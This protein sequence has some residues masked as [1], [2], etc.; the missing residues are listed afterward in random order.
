MPS[1]AALA[2]LLPLS[3]GTGDVPQGGVF[4]GRE[5]KLDVPIPRLNA[6]IKL[7]GKL[8]DEAWKR[9]AMLTG[10]SQFQPAD[11]RPSTDSTEVL[12]WYSATAIHFG[13]RAHE[14][15]GVINANLADRDRI[16]ADDYVQILLGTFND[17][18]QA[19]M[20]AVNPLGVQADGTMNEGTG[21]RGGGSFSAATGGRESADLSANFVFESRGR[22]VEGGYEVEIT[23]PFKSLRYQS[24][25]VQ[26]WG[27]H[28]MRTV[29]HLGH[30]DSWVPASRANASFLSQGGRLQGLRDLRRGLVMDVTPSVVARQVGDE[31]EDGA[32]GYLPEGPEYGATVR[33]GLTNNL[34]LNATVNPDFS[35]VE[36]DVGAI[37]F[38]PRSEVFFPERR[39]FFL[40]GI[41][42]FSTPNNLV[43]SRRIVQPDAALKL[44]GKAFGT[45]IAVMS[46]LDDKLTSIGD[47]ERPMFNIVRLTRDVGGQSRVGMVY[48]DKRDG[49]YSN[50]V[51]GV[52]ARLLFK[53]MWTV[54]LQAA[55]SWT[56]QGLGQGMQSAPLWRSSLDRNGRAFGMTYT[57]AGISDE[58]ITR[59]GFISR[60]GVVDA[61]FNH[62]YT[63]FG[64]KGARVESF[65]TAFVPQFKWKWDDFFEGDGVIERKF[66]FNNTLAL[67][68]G[69]RVTGSVLL[70]TFYYDED[71]YRGYLVEV[72][73]TNGAG[74]DTIPFTGT[75]ALDNL[76]W[77]VNIA[78]PQW[79]RFAG[80]FFYVWGQDENFFEW[81]SSD[82]DIATV[83]MDWRP[84]DRARIDFQYQLQKYDRKTDGS[85][86]GRRRI[87]R[88]KVEYQ[89]ARPL[90]FR[91]VGQ[92]DS[93]ERDALR[94]DSRTEGPL[95]R[96][97]AD[98]TI[99][100]LD[101]PRILNNLRTD[102]LLSY[103]PVPGTVFFAGYGSTMREAE[104]LKF[105]D[106]SRS[107]DGF[108]VKLSYLWR[109]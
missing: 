8:D 14:A 10:F 28:V 41:E 48:T 91:V 71:L 69:W 108:F 78:T 94:D 72:P 2:F 5:R 42:T 86:V 87:P 100:R 12:V 39:P 46:A 51:A 97:L 70:E 3:L 62:R 66:H 55:N 68:G 24:A 29:Q 38:D 73:A 76:D 85:T 96:T 50:Q 74:L 16:F 25:E 79:G 32:W 89:V 9:A 37:Q 45:N 67:R 56:N 61:N 6:E 47:D 106:L 17:G 54:N 103:Q 58:F 21:G 7:D 88:L 105:N 18:R 33:W 82:I 19:F 53:Q 65:S 64:R 75:P 83:T 20:F 23:V 109:L 77:V 81:S 44:T 101:S 4:N 104:S 43:Y 11:G 49:D 40:E 13:I 52:D 57:F 95:L 60:T 30:E 34:T 84:T 93:N 22:V 102:W 90:F 31:K 36:A 59:S 1:I 26:T 80:T 107:D 63:W 35:Q 92:Y 99:V 27:I 98:G 15:H